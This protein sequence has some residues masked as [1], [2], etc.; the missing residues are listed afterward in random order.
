MVLG[1][2][3]GLGSHIRQS[4]DRVV[5]GIATILVTLA[6]INLN[7]AGSGDWTGRVMV[8]LSWVTI[9]SLSM[10]L[11]AAVSYRV[12]YRFAYAA[13]FAGVGLLVL[14]SLV[15]V[16]RNQARRWLDF[17]LQFQPSEF[18]KILL[19][20][21]LARYLHDRPPDRQSRLIDK[22][23]PYG[24]MLLP[25][26]FVYVQPDLGTGVMLLLISL[27]MLVVTGLSPRSVAGIVLSGVAALALSWR[28]MHEYQRKRVE[29]WLDPDLYADKEGYQTIQS[30]ISVGNGGF[31]GRGVG[32]GTQN[33]LD[34]Q[35]E[36]FTDFAF[37]L[38]AEEW[39]FIGTSIVLLL[40]MVLI[41][42]A[43]NLAAQAQN[44][45]GVL[46]C[47]GVAAMFFWH[48]IIS[49]GMVLQLIP[50]VGITMPFFSSGGSSALTMM[51]GLGVLMSASRSRAFR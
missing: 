20:L 34:F 42:W 41:L 16:T 9:G 51:A 28:H 5:V 26:G 12:L 19:V 4:I 35:P 11:L 29:V 36:P 31:L 39:G 48:V 32:R 38:F 30:L 44:Q 17:G 40:Y 1:R 27:S 25:F 22:L 10:G 43:I 21:A 46:V 45:F 18:M 13:Y 3:P 23:M 14:V 33:V 2:P 7:S 37:A 24:M 15:G 49:A 6:L 47:I 8:Q 50:V